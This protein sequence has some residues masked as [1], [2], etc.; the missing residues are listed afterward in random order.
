MRLTPR[1]VNTGL[2]VVLVAGIAGTWVALHGSEEATAGTERTTRVTRGGVTATVSGTGNITSARTS[3]VDFP[4]GGTLTAVTVE[5]GEIVEKGEVLARVDRDDAERS[6]ESARARLLATQAS[7]NTLV[8][9]Q[10]ALDRARS[11]LNVS[12]AGSS[13]DSASSSLTSARRQLTSDTKT[14]NALVTAA[15]KALAEG[16]G[17]KGAVTAARRTRTQVLTKDQEAVTRAEQQLASAQ[18]GLQEARNKAA[19]DAQGPSDSEVAQALS[20]LHSARAAV[21][22][23]RETVR[24][25]TLR[26][27]QDGTVLSVSASEGESVGSG[28]STGSGSSSA[29]S[30]S[31]GSSSGGSSSGSGGSGGSGSAS[32]SSASGSSSSGSSSGSSASGSSS[33]GLIVLADLT[34]LEVTASIAEADVTDLEKGQ[35]AQIT[36]SASGTTVSGTVTAVALQGTTS[37]NVVQYP[38][39][40]QLDEAPKGVR[41]GASARI[42]ITTGSAD[43]VLSVPSSAVTTNGRRSTVTVLRGTVRS[44]VQVETGLKGNSTTEITSGLSE[45]DTVVLSSGSDS[46]SLSNTRGVPGMG[47]GMGGMGGFGGGARP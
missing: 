39:T 29:G 8:A 11:R 46:S 23:A 34:R 38:V 36:L 32:G 25:T 40:V 12:K 35:E 26:A 22:D 13:V 47:G 17:S 10:S 2:A 41:L 44:V 37:G 28:S 6:L 45:G 9:G 27:P 24:N 20:D 7:Y 30:S 14:Q 42:T 4:S 33:T 15:E 1:W 21:E 16:T 3:T 5:V 43:D 18:L 19:T 31:A